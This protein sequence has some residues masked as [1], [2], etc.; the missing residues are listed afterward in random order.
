MRD[1]LLTAS[2]PT[3]RA[4]L[5]GAA[6]ALFG[7][8]LL[9][10]PTPGWSD[11][12]ASIETG[13]R[14]PAKR[15]IMLSMAGGMSHLDTLDPKPGTEQAGP[16]KAIAGA[17]DGVQLSEYLPNLAKMTKHCA[18]VRSLTSTQGAHETGTYLMRTSFQPRG[19]IIHP[20]MGA[21]MSHFAGRDNPT[22]P[23]YIGVNIGGGHP[24]AGYLDAKDGPMPVTADSGLAN[25]IRPS[26][27]TV[28]QFDRR[29]QLL[30]AMDGRFA[31][32]FDQKA[33]KSYGS[34]YD[35]AVSLMSSKDLDAFNLSQESPTL[36]AA[37]GD[38]AFG[39]GCL[40]ARRLI[41]HDVRAVEVV[42]GGWDTHDDNFDR[43]ADQAL[44]LDAALPALLADLDARGLLDETLVVVNTEFGRTPRISERVGR[45]HFPKAFSCLLAGA[46]IR[47]GIAYGATD[48]TGSEV[49][50]GK[51]SIPDFNCT[52]AHALGLPW[53]RT[54]ISPSGRPFTLADKGKP[55][56]DLLA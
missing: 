52:I 8:S 43:V 49:V 15:L 18:V 34:I 45:D 21:W 32:T 22:L 9:S 31:A 46:G 24:G 16:V 25:S 1:P 51:L 56:L 40:L 55:A 6:Q 19:T 11:E 47:R 37:Y 4:V 23:A 36:R 3:R 17:A 50:S 30:K 10:L 26:S 12:P 2:E 44:I 28:G 27:V 35:E 48:A 7:L 13:P 38:T 29:I 33:V 39:R 53:Q 5:T 14:F 42:L 41:E 20:T 54:V